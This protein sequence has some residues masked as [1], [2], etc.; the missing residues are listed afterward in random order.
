MDSKIRCT[1][2]AAFQKIANSNSTKHTDLYII[3]SH[4]ANSTEILDFAAVGEL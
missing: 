3:P 2:L 4:I 1:E